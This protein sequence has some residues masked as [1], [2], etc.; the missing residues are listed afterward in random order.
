MMKSWDYQYMHNPLIHATPA[1][2]NEV[3]NP[4]DVVRYGKRPYNPGKISRHTQ[5]HYVD[6]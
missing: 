3:A 6:T 1:L 4:N 5:A 2:D